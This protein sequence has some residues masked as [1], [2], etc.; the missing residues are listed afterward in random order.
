MAFYDYTYN[1][2]AMLSCPWTIRHE[3]EDLKQSGHFEEYVDYFKWRNRKV[4]YYNAYV[5]GK[6]SFIARFFGAFEE[7]KSYKKKKELA[8]DLYKRYKDMMLWY[9]GE[10]LFSTLVHI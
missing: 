4:S 3:I 10:E 5:C 7:R 9:Y 6:S 1:S 8:K 2:Q